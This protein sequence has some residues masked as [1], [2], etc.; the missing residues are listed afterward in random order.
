M[1][2]L[3]ATMGTPPLVQPTP[4]LINL[5]PAWQSEGRLPSSGSGRRVAIPPSTVR[6]GTYCRECSRERRD[7]LRARLAGRVDAWTRRSERFSRLS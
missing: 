3:A 5:S 7:Y 4:P 6:G 2:L 1:G